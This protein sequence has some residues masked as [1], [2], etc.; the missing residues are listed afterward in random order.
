MIDLVE[1]GATL[2][3]KAVDVHVIDGIEYMA[4]WYFSPRDA[5]LMIWLN[6]EQEIDRYQ[7]NSGGQIVDWS[8]SEGLRTGFIVEIEL[9]GESGKINVGATEIAETIQFDLTLSPSVLYRAKVIVDNCSAFSGPM[10]AVI[11]TSLT[12]DQSKKA[13]LGSVSSSRARFWGRFKR[14]TIGA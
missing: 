4:R 13:G 11:L 7:L 3:E 5:D 9:T 14:W 6:S 1:Q 12:E 2:T 8:R 10:K